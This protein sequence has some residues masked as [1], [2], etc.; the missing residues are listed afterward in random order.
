MKREPLAF[1]LFQCLPGGSSR[2]LSTYI[3]A[4]LSSRDLAL[5]YIEGGLILARTY[6]VWSL[7]HTG[8]TLILSQGVRSC[9]KSEIL[10]QPEDSGIPESLSLSS[11]PYMMSRRESSSQIKGRRRGRTGRTKRKSKGEGRKVCYIV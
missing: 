11:L 7:L 8:I 3:I 1:K 5:C 2:P 6:L 4:F 10:S 9:A